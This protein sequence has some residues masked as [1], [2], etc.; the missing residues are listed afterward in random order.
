MFLAASRVLG[1][2][3]M[4]KEQMDRCHFWTNPVH[5]CVR[6][7]KAARYGCAL[8]PTL[9]PEKEQEGARLWRG[10]AVLPHESCDFMLVI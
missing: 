2:T 5:E 3:E 8:G 1:V 9:N 4:G 7:S 6:E 10:G